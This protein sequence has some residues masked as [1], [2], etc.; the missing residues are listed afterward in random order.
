MDWS[1]CREPVSAWTHGAWML[2]ALP[3]SWLLWRRTRGEPGK[4]IGISVF[5]FSMIFCFAA[6]WL[7]HSVPPAQEE[8][9]A[10]LDH[11]GIYMLIAGTVTP[12]A[13]VVL[14]GYWRAWLLTTVWVMAVTG[15]AL[16]LTID[17]PP[18]VAT[19]FYLAMGWIGCLTY[20]ELA[21]SLSHAGVR[22]IWLG[23]VFYTLG[24][25]IH[26]L[27]WPVLSPGAFSSHDLF[28]LFVMA[29]SFCHY[30]F[31]YAVL[32]PYRGRVLAR[33]AAQA[34]AVEPLPLPGR[35][36]GNAVEG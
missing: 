9:F 7:F 15:S 19:S 3:G 22:P 13:L 36:A 2:L 14:R 30:Y 26:R 20:C 4:R 25:F 35:L 5:C 23:G 34:P 28:H 29:G 16:R 10:V 31:M 32:A 17:L 12:I 21:R 1:Y 24:A 8:R 6:S 33:A 27:G 11:I 18:W